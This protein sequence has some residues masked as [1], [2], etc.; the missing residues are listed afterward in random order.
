MARGR[1]LARSP[2]PLTVN[3]N[4]AFVVWSKERELFRSRA[5]PPALKLKSASLPKT[6]AESPLK[7]ALVAGRA[8]ACVWFI[9]RPVKVRDMIRLIEK[10]GWI[11]HSQKGGHRQYV[12]RVKK[13]R[14]T[15]PVNQG[16]TSLQ[17]HCGAS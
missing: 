1:G 14:V 7:T 8:R 15:F 3:E 11:F 12:H 10:D 16:T 5:F 9:L 4:G 13:G 17:E 2:F 6:L